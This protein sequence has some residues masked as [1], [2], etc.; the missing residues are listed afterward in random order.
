M[1]PELENDARTKRF[2]ARLA[3]LQCHEGLDGFELLISEAMNGDID[4][5]LDE[6]A[7]RPL[8]SEQD[9]VLLVEFL[10][11]H[12]PRHIGRGSGKKARTNRRAAKWVRHERA[13]TGEDTEKLL[14]EA[15]KKFGAKKK[16][17]RELVRGSSK[18]LK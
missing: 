16:T 10:S 3:R 6:I 15:V 12:L 9:R 4:L 14:D 8:T 1:K 17:T 18:R 2:L 11:T 7:S 5:L 13:K